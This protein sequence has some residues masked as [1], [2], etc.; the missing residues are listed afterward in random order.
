MTKTYGLKAI[1]A[2]L[3]MA[4][5]APPLLASYDPFGDGTESWI[6]RYIVD[7]IGFWLQ[8][9]DQYGCGGVNK[10]PLSIREIEGMTG[11]NQDDLEATSLDGVGARWGLP[12]GAPLLPLPFT[13]KQFLDFDA[14]CNGLFSGAMERPVW[15]PLP[16]S[17]LENAADL[18][19]EGRNFEAERIAELET[20][21]PEAAE[22]AKIILSGVA[23][24]SD[25][26]IQDSLDEAQGAIIV[27]QPK[28]RVQ[29]VKILELL[30]QESYNPSKLPRIVKG[31]SGAKAKIKVLACAL[32]PVIFTESTFNKAWQR[33]R[34][35]KEI[36][37]AN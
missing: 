20:T 27:Q 15:Q 5:E 37:D 16:E 33:L 12:G 2:L 35:G 29:E 3:P 10:S 23:P 32:K 4:R 28:L 21:N 1:R 31:K 17:E 30:K 14:R 18:E 26:A 11:L 7:S 6:V 36:S 9:N 13:A 34:S 19:P 8:V 22:L 24:V 25:S